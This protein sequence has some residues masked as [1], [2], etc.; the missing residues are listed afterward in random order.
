MIEDSQKTQPQP[1]QLAPGVY[2]LEVLFPPGWFPP[3]APA[4][5]LCYL[6]K[7]P[8]GWLMVDSGFNHDYSFDS[9]CRQLDSL[10]ISLQDIR[11]LLITHFHP[12][13][14]GLAGWVKAYS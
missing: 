4:A 6:V 13:H 10:G 14:M 12:D 5:T 7:M 1:R 8:E 11:W 2:M 9:L 3:D